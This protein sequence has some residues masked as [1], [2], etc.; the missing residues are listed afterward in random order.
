MQLICTTGLIMSYKENI[1][2]NALEAVALIYH[3]SKYNDDVDLY[4]S[5]DII[6]SLN[7]NQ[8]KSK[9]WL[10]ECLLPFIKTNRLKRGI[11]KIAIVGSWYGLLGIMLRQHISDDIEIVCIDADVQTKPIAQ[12]LS[13]G[14]RYKNNR[15][16]VEDAAEY[17]TARAD[18]F[19]LIINTSC[20]H[21]E[22][23]DVK[24]IVGLKNKNAIICFQS[25][26]YKAIDSHINTSD[27][28]EDFV[29]DLDLVEVL[30]SDSKQ[31]DG[32]ETYDRYT[33]IG[34]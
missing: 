18:S 20:E 8:M 25:N 2:R 5:I 4:R 1:Y 15:Y 17:L 26:N 19:D 16:V 6:N 11:R 14:D 28:L 10:I 30:F 7:H 22:K 12:K 27:S 31:F 29:E 3:K 34:I 21:M 13:Q 24:F 33:V 23:E 32:V 9:E